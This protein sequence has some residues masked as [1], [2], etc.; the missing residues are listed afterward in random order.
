[1]FYFGSFFYKVIVDLICTH[2]YRYWFR[3]VNCFHNILYSLVFS[4]FT[5]KIIW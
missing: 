3:Q 2:L 5:P 4:I 1:M